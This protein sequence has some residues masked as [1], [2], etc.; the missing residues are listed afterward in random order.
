[1]REKLQ[2]PFLFLFITVLD[3]GGS[4]IIPMPLLNFVLHTNDIQEFFIV[5]SLIFNLHIVFLSNCFMCSGILIY[6][7]YLY[8]LMYVYFI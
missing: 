7:V 1:M 8:T 4:A 6:H 5:K 2:T 3:I